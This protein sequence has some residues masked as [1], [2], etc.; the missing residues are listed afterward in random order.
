MGVM[1]GAMSDPPAVQIARMFGVAQCDL[2]RVVFIEGLSNFV[3]VGLWVRAVGRWNLSF[4]TMKHV[5]LGCALS[6]TIIFG[7]SYVLSMLYPIFQGVQLPFCCFV[8][9]VG[10]AHWCFPLGFLFALVANA[11]LPSRSHQKRLVGHFVALVVIT[12]I[13]VLQFELYAAGARFYAGRFYEFWYIAFGF[14][15][16]LFCFLYFSLF[17]SL[18]LVG[19]RMMQ[20]RARGRGMR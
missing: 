13:A 11:Q 4:Y 5:V 18:L 15:F 2:H 7:G 16:Y 8:R 17:A 14:F 19:G 12:L 10:G 20:K 3:V 9:K 6:A 1:V